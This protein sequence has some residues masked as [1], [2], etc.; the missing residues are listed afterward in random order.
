LA[1]SH[2]PRLGLKASDQSHQCVL[3]LVYD[4]AARLAT[5]AQLGAPRARCCASGAARHCL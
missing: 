3:R 5:G 2:V 4:D 1:L